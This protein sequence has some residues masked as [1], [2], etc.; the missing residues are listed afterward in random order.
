MKFYI[1]Y[2]YPYSED[3]IFRYPLFDF[4]CKYNNIKAL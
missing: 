2:I 1:V 3:Q 4:N